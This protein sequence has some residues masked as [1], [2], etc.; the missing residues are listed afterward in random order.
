MRQAA[1]ERSEM[2]S[3]TL[4]R[5]ERGGAHRRDDIENQ[6]QWY[7]S[8]T[9][10]MGRRSRRYSNR[11]RVINQNMPRGQNIVDIGGLAVHHKIEEL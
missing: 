4:R 7:D 2:L 10:P 9:N 8:S 6:R 5:I 1:R 11:Y 3:R